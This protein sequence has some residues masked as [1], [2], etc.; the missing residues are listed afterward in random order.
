MKRDQLKA[1]QAICKANYTANPA[2]AF[3]TLQ[4][5]G[6]V[7]FDNLAV[8][9]EHP[10]FWNPAGLHPSGGGDGSFAC[11]VEIMLAGLVSCAG[12]T[13]AAVA[14][15]MQLPITAARVIAEGDID[16]RGTLAVDKA[17]PMGLVQVRLKWEL[18]TT[19]ETSKIDKLL[20]LTHRYCVV[21]R[22]LES[23]PPI[24]TDYRVVAPTA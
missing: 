9:L 19:A 6:R 20:E 10:A 7:D 18:E 14:T 21:H 11:P 16:F 1:Q 24:T 17:A 15:S 3:Q 8:Q 12:V 4:A 22:T 13:L 2:T 23:P 5:R